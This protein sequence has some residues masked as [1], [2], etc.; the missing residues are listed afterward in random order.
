MENKVN[1]AYPFSNPP[2]ARLEDKIQ[3]IV[4]CYADIVTRADRAFAM[5]QLRTHLREVVIYERNTVWRDMI[6]AH[7]KGYT[8]QSATAQP[9]L[10]GLS[11]GKTAE[12]VKKAIKWKSKELI[13]GVVGIT[14]FAV[15]V[16]L[17]PL[18]RQ[19]ESNCLAL[20]ILASVFWALEVSISGV[21][22]EDAL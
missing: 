8:G 3:V 11:D 19:E 13:G 5:K 21:P 15:I 16:Q 12:V 22:F 6:G 10:A 17:Q 2:R 4:S 7:T 9:V 1:S 14:A 20:I 18:G